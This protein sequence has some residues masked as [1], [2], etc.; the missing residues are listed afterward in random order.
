MAVLHALQVLAGSMYDYGHKFSLCA[1]PKSVFWLERARQVLA[2]LISGMLAISCLEFLWLSHRNPW[3]SLQRWY[4]RLGMDV[5]SFPYRMAAGRGVR[6]L[7]AYRGRPSYYD[8]RYPTK[9]EL[10]ELLKASNFLLNCKQ[11][12]GEIRPLALAI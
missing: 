6:R 12:F 9:R 3:I 8:T 5:F 10:Q 7:Y 11:A 1:H 2:D 4:L